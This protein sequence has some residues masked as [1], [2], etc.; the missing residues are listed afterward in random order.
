MQGVFGMTYFKF[1]F[2]SLLFFVGCESYTVNTSQS[3]IQ[4]RDGCVFIDAS[5]NQG[6]DTIKANYWITQYIDDNNMRSLYGKNGLIITLYI[7]SIITWS[8]VNYCK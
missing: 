2:L 6:Q 1:L 7:P 8:E 4:N 3:D 5:F